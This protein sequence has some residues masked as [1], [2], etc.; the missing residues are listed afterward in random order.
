M[1]E[2]ISLS[3]VQLIVHLVKYEQI[4]QR[5]D[6]LPPGFF[7]EKLTTTE[8]NHSIPFAPFASSSVHGSS[9][10][11]RDE[12]PASTMN[13]STSAKNNTPPQ[14]TTLSMNADQIVDADDDL[15]HLMNLPKAPELR[16]VVRLTGC[17]LMCTSSRF[18]IDIRLDFKFPSEDRIRS[19]LILADEVSD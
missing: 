6:V 14:T 7:L 11:S 3:L 12:I 5:H 2:L 13:G 17:S 16:R 9:R 8:N 1:N 10:C 4:I 18:H 15:A 19:T